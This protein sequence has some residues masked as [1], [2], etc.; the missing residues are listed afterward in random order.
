MQMT[1]VKKAVLFELPRGAVTNIAWIQ[2]SLWSHTM[3]QEYL[4][5]MVISTM[6]LSQPCD[7][8]WD[9]KKYSV[10][11]Q[12]G[13]VIDSYGYQGNNIFLH[14]AKLRLNFHIKPYIIHKHSVLTESVVFFLFWFLKLGELIQLVELD[15]Y[16][17]DNGIYYLWI[18]ICSH[19]MHSTIYG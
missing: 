2:K 6:W 1:I 17:M 16:F 10:T 11:S 3:F 7:L 15:K 4:N 8:L 18:V 12:Y 14:Q 5:F 13:G 9:F 19:F